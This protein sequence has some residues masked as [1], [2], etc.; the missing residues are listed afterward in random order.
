MAKK[1][2]TT[3]S[4]GKVRIGVYYDYDLTG[5]GPPFGHV[6]TFHVELT[7]KG[8]TIV[9]NASAGENLKKMVEE[10][11]KPA[12]DKKSLPYDRGYSS[13]SYEQRFMFP[14]SLTAKQIEAEIPFQSV[15]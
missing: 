12:G 7:L 15:L 11:G 1:G 9:R 14:A 5:G 6:R 4:S 10:R 8:K 3:L 2:A 13:K